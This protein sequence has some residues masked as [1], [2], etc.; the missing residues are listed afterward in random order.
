MLALAALL[1]WTIL[2]AVRQRHTP[3]EIIAPDV[4]RRILR[5]LDA[6]QSLQLQQSAS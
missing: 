1:T 4:D 5:W 3:F 6:S 2:I